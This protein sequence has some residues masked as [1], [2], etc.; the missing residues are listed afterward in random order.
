MKYMAEVY[1]LFRNN[2]WEFRH[3]EIPKWMYECMDSEHVDMELFDQIY[4]DNI[5]SLKV[6]RKYTV[7]D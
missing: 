4:R 5:C 3:I 6:R 2:T 7:N 1:V